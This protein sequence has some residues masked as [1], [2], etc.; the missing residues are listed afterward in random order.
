MRILHTADWHLND[1]LGRIDRTDD[2]RQAVE[3][4][5]RLCHSERIDVLIVAGDLFS[6]LA[7]PDALRE[8]IHHWQQVFAEFLG[9]GGTI[10]T[11][12]GNHDN[13]NFCQTLRHAMALAAPKLGQQG[14][15][16]PPGR[17]YLAA[18][19]TFLRLQDPSGAFAVPFLLMPYPTPTRYLTGES[20]QKYTTPDEKNA[21]LVKAF[22]RTIRE[23]RQH[24][25]FDQQAPAVLVAHVQAY[26]S[27][28]GQSLFRM[29]PHEDV[30]VKPEFW[31]EQFA[32]VALGHVHKPQS[33]GA[34]HVRYSGS[35]EKMDLGEQHDA[36]GVCVVELD[37]QG[38]RGPVQIVGLPSTPIYDVN[39]FDP[40]VDLPR[41]KAEAV[42]AEKD[43]VNLHILYQAGRDHLEEI[44][45]ELDRL[46]PRWYARDWKETGQMGTP[47]TVGEADRSRG[48]GETVREY[49]GQEL[50]TQEEAERTEL[51][52]LAEELIAECE[53]E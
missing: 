45:K 44:L 30:V 37:A 25:A 9:R 35:I 1:R 3:R 13:E 27:E 47:L 21:L 50:L 22:S 36:K 28:L 39:V 12:T 34:E 49:L 17:L 2:L 8:S 14:E 16:V 33:L 5:A 48:F 51:L 7:R 6:E 32:Y 42:G 38:R 53:E 46:F 23:M 26:G 4:V 41:L 18:E 11:L 43:L 40:A 24:P 19:P 15:V 52:R 31:A 20:G 10:L 29:L